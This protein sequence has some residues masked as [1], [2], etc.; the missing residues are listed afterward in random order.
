MKNTLR[1]VLKEKRAQ[2]E[3]LNADPEGDKRTWLKEIRGL[4]SDIRKWLKLP[5]LDQ[6]VT[7]REEKEPRSEDLLGDYKV[8]VLVVRFFNG[9]EIRFRPVAYHV[10]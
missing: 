1:D 5:V 4:F 9:R 10:V 8:P 2:W 6:T 3:G 7:I